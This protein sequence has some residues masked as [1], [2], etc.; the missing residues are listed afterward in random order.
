MPASVAIALNDLLWWNASGPYPNKASNQADAGSLVANQLAFAQ[1]FFGVSADQRLAGETTTGVDAQRVSIMEGVFD[2]PCTSATFT[3]GQL[4]GIDRNSGDSVNYNQQVIAVT[5]PALA[6]GQVL[7][8]GSSL[9]TVRCWLSAY[10]FGFFK[11]VGASAFGVNGLQTRTMT[12]DVTAA[13]NVTL[14]TLTG[15]TFNV[16]A[17][18]KY[19]FT[20]TLFVSSTA[21]GGTKVG[22]GGTATATSIISEIKGFTT[23]T[24]NLSAQTTAIGSLGG[25]TAAMDS[26]Q[27]RGEI[28]VNAGGTLIFQGA[29]TASH[30][31]TT[32]FKTGSFVELRPAA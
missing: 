1:L 23:T 14:A 4:V 28:V 30:S 16:S 27:I 18:R 8:P 31:D 13:T 15:L 6:I 11:Y 5:D 2:C 19:I 29:Q 12:A 26:V 20:G 3:V 22:I 9:T 17:G 24:A 25:A 32:T 21:N 10:E 7:I